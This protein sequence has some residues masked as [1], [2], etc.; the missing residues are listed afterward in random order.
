[1]DKQYGDMLLRFFLEDVGGN[2][3]T[4]ETGSVL[5]EDARA[6]AIRQDRTN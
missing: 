5:Y 2:L 3:I 1:M 6:R 4:D